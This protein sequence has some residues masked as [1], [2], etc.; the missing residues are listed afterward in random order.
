MRVVALLNFY[1]FAVPPCLA[2]E[3]NKLRAERDAAASAAAELR[4][5]VGGVQ[6]ALSRAR[7]DLTDRVHALEA[8]LHMKSSQLGQ[9]RGALES[10]E[11]EL[12]R[13]RM[14]A[15][16]AAKATAESSA[17]SAELQAH[18][19]GLQVRAVA[20]ECVAVDSLCADVERSDVCIFYYACP[21]VYMHGPSRLSMASHSS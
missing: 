17:R 16:A 6:D 7:A 13:A 11:A 14:Q 3:R 1:L 4:A 20:S 8:D 21:C 12:V 19:A 5:Q 2:A 10:A 18:V 9:C 15:E